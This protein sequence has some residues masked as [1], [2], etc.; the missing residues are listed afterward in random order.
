MFLVEYVVFFRVGNGRIEKIK[1]YTWAW[2]RDLNSIEVTNRIANIKYVSFSQI[3]L[4]NIF[5]KLD[6]SNCL[7]AWVRNESRDL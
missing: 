1:V 5:K 4:F 2:E 6:L 3:Q 7:K